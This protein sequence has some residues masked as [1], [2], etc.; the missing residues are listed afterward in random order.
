MCEQSPRRS[1][2]VVD[3]GRWIEVSKIKVERRLRSMMISIGGMNEG[4]AEGGFLSLVAS[5]REEKEWTFQKKN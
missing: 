3:G 5:V 1:S 4:V 2:F